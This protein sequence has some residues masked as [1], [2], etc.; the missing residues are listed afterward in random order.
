MA[1]NTQAAKSGSGLEPNIAAMLAWIFAPISSVIFLMTDPNDKFIKF[2]ALQSLVWSIA[3]VIIASI[4]SATII[5]ACIAW[6]PFV[7]TLYGAYKAYNKEMWKLPVIG[8]WVEKQ[9]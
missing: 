6:V 9:L 5:L 3:A 8:D 2:H 4:M 7:V 1:E